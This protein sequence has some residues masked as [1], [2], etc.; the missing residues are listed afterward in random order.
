[1]NFS[2]LTFNILANR[3]TNYNKGG[4]GNESR[5][6]MEQRYL[7][8]ILILENLNKDIY[9]LQEVDSHFYKL[10][11]LSDLKKKYFITYRFHKAW[12]TERNKDD[13]GLLIMVKNSSKFSTD[14][15]Y[16]MKFVTEYP[17]NSSALGYR[18]GVSGL[19]DFIEL[20]EY[21]ERGNQRKFSQIL[22]IKNN[23]NQ[24]L[25]LVNLHLEGRPDYYQLRESEFRDSFT[26]C[27]D[28]KKKYM[29][30]KETFYLLSGDF[31]EPDQKIVE[32]NLIKDLPLKLI[33]ND[34]DQLTSFTKYYTDKVTNARE[35]IDKL[36][37][38]DY[39]I[40]SKKINCQGNQL[41]PNFDIID[42]PN[43]KENFIVES[44]SGLELNKTN[45]P[46]DHKLLYFLLEL[47]NKKKKTLKKKNKNIKKSHKL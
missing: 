45:W 22:I 40:C 7:A 20:T 43:W 42:F 31:N 21:G 34:S 28:F 37:K 3:F 38:L 17:P 14:E 11:M 4:T 46:S 33:N 19:F 32:D 2:F 15:E 27:A 41:L 35:I 36:Q 44:N 47:P 6:E 30:N 1:M 10:L 9:F 26:A 8:I 12:P 25:F 29:K 39:L 23:Q 16:N 18:G 5:Q 24:Y 13:I